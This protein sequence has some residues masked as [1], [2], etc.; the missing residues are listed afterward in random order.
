MARGFIAAWALASGAR[1]SIGPRVGLRVVA[2]G[3]PIPRVSLPAPDESG[4]LCGGG[5][6]VK[7]ICYFK[8]PPLHGAMV[9]PDKVKVG[10]SPERDIF[11]EDEI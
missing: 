4:F 8:C 2:R 3:P 5:E 10:D 7:E 6:R 1:G 9:R 11:E